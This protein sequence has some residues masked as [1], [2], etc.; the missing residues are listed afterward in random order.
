MVA[1]CYVCQ[2]KGSFLHLDRYICN[3]CFT[4][5]I[6]KRVKHHLGRNLFKPN[7][8]ILVLG[9]LEYYFLS[10]VIKGMP[11]QITF[12]S[13]LPS[14]LTAFKHIILG[15]T[16]DQLDEDF[17]SGLFDGKLS[18]PTENKPFFNI[19][20]PLTDEEIDKYAQ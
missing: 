9:K 20:A 4:K 6:E 16:L 12:K 14:D 17:L 10:Q 15:K 3:K 19:L 13:K 8:T 5:N 18:L 1:E 2:G 11:L 7:D